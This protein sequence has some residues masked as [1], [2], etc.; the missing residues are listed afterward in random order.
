MSRLPALV[1]ALASPAA[2]AKTSTTA[3]AFFLWPGLIDVQGPAIE[4]PP[5]QRGNRLFALTVI[6]HFDEAKAPGAPGFA[7][8][9]D[10]HTIHRAVSLKH[11]SNRIFSSTETEISNKNV[12]H[13]IFF[14]KVARQRI[15]GKRIGAVTGL[16]VK[17]K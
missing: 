17:P 9:Y 4:F 10:V 8:G 1:V 11:R 12:L 14:L 13:L 7:V 15:T 5:I 2:A 16:Y 6:T 3:A